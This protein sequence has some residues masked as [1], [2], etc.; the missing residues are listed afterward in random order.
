MSRLI[1]VALV[2][3]GFACTPP[4]PVPVG[5][6][7]AG[8]DAGV[9]AG[10]LCEQPAGGFVG[11][12]TLCGLCTTEVAQYP[13]YVL[14]TPGCVVDPY[15]VHPVRLACP[16][17]CPSPTDADRGTPVVFTQGQP[18]DAGPA[19]TSVFPAPA[20]IT[21]LSVPAGTRWVVA[22]PG[23]R[24]ASCSAATTLGLS[25]F[26]IPPA[27]GGSVQVGRFAVSSAGVPPEGTV[28][29][30]LASSLTALDGSVT[31]TALTPQVVGTFDLQMSGSVATGEVVQGSFEAIPCTAP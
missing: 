23:D 26:F 7:D 25:L 28:V 29:A 13:L 18:F 24:Q 15:C 22:R 17:S 5:V 20:S 27:D 12:S 19:L 2:V 3:T 14:H 6:P 31:L 9:D 4:S 30:T 21:A 8:S 10:S 1:L 16:A 11:C